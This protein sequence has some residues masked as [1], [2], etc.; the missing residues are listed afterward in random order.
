MRGVSVQ[1]FDIGGLQPAKRRADGTMVVDAYFGRIG[2]QLYSDGKGGVR[3]ELRLPEHVFEKASLDSFG[4]ITVTNNHPDTG[5]IN[6]AVAS[7]YA[8][9]MTGDVVARDGSRMRGKIALFDGGAI[10]AAESGKVQLSNGYTCDLVH[11]SG[12]HPEFGEYDAI[13]TNIR[14]NHVAIVDAG[15]A[16][17]ECRMRVDGVLVEGVQMPAAP[18]EF[19]LKVGDRV[20]AYS[21]RAIAGEYGEATI[22]EIVGNEFAVEFDTRPGVV[23]RWFNRTELTPIRALRPDGPGES[24]KVDDGRL[25]TGDQKSPR[26]R[27]MDPEEALRALGVKVAQLETSNTKL[28][29]DLKTATNRAAAAEAERDLLK[30]KVEKLEAQRLDES[31]AL[32]DATVKRITAERDELQKKLDGESA[33]FDLA[34]ADRAGLLSQAFAVLGPDRKDL[35]GMTDRNVRIEMIKHLDS[36]VDVSEKAEDA[37]L[38][39]VGSMLYADFVSGAEARARVAETLAGLGSRRSRADVATA[40]VQTPVNPYT[41]ERVVARR[42]AAS[43]PLPSAKFRNTGR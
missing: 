39:A 29:S 15:R 34:V 9:G 27:G 24:K 37:A 19:E 33:R 32:V 43:Q 26:M 14:G 25:L 35:A 23:A 18:G 6:A 28:D 16:G 42:Y 38:K 40:P 20:Y 5:L 31:V 8:V 36:T 22:R 41:G 30:G 7:R 13:Q 1:R 10:D 4:N 11:Q 12:V 17:P 21:P 3:R 2:V